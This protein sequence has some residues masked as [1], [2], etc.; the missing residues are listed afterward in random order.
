VENFR[1][2]GVRFC[3]SFSD[4]VT[5]EEYV[6]LAIMDATQGKSAMNDIADS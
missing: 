6:N 1:N 4:G 5:V 2:N 3:S